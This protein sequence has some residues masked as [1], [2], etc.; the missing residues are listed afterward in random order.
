MPGESPQSMM[1]R[2][3]PRRR[4]AGSEPGY[5][6]GPWRALASAAAIL[7]VL[8]VA[9][10]CLW[11]Y[12]ATTADRT[13]A[14]WVD[15]EKAAGRTYSCGTQTIGGFP[16]RV[17]VRCAEATAEISSNQPPF[18][19]TAKD[20]L[21]A[22]QVY[23][24][25]RLT[26]DVSGPLTLSE[27]GNP[28][29]LIAN[30]ARARLT[31]H[32]LPPD[33]DYA[34]VM[35]D[36]PRL[37]RVG[38]ADGASGGVTLFQAK[39]GDLLGRLVAGSPNNNPVIEAVLKINAATAP[40]MHALTAKPIDG[41]V[42]AVLRGFKDLKSRPWADHFREMAAAAGG[43]EIKHLRLQRPD[44]IIVG[45]GALSVNSNG[46][47]NGLIRLAVVGIENIIPL[48]GVD[49][50]IG[51]G[52]DRLTGTGAAAEGYGALDR[53]V[54]GLGGAV[55]DTANASLIDNIKKMGQPTEIDKK[56]AIVLPLRFSDGVMTLG[57]LPL[58]EVA[59]L[60]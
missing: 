14:G 55:R 2:P 12:G 32:G 45:A 40:T 33:P 52:I 20:V 54:P 44:A 60:F 41:E 13:L 57:L 34:S 49:H 24:P 56:P 1:R 11:Y 46:K 36:R 25:T 16:F 50:L 6:R 30:W 10:V 19:V 7:V 9:W 21:V 31:V 27:Q 59:P 26:A 43:I 17:E 53:L 23:R 51:Q 48:L 5:R 37:D 22:A 18:A 35:L 42:D 28:V 38:A 8:A 47:L 58:G 15:R 39:Y 3:N 29:S 4:G